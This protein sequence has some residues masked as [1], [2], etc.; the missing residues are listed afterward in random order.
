MELGHVVC[1][2]QAQPRVVP[3]STDG[4]VSH[5]WLSSCGI[6]PAQNSEESKNSK[7]ESDF[8]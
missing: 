8:L 3:C 2:V 6:I 4:A 7:F 5:E 1:S